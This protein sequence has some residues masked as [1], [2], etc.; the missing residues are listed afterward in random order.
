MIGTFTP[1]GGKAEH[2]LRVAGKIGTLFV[3]ASAFISN[4]D[5]YRAEA[6]RLSGFI[7]QVAGLARTPPGAGIEVAPEHDGGLG[8]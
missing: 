6:D 2:V 3:Q 7:N 1:S 5:D 4:P 8:A